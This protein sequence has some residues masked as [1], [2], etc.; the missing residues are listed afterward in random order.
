MKKIVI[1]A[2]T[3]FALTATALSA[4]SNMDTDGDGLLSYNELLAAHPDM[5]EEAFVA[6]DTNADGAVD[7]DELQVAGDAGLLKTEG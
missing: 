3:V 4:Q 1:Q 2:A 5:T 6:I 7:A